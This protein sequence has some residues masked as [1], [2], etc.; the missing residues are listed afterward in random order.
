VLP[1][2]RARQLVEAAEVCAMVEWLPEASSVR[3]RSLERRVV[4]AVRVHVPKLM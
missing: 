1:A 3:R 4:A 2:D